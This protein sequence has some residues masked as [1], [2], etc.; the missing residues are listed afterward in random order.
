MARNLRFFRLLS[1]ES[2]GKFLR[3]QFKHRLLQNLLVGL[4]A[5]VGDKAALLCSE[6]VAGTTNV[7][8][9]HCNLNA[10]AQVAETLDGI[11]SAHCHRGERTLRRNGEVAERLAVAASHTP[12]ELVQI[13][14]TVVL[15]VVDNDGVH[16]RHVDATLDD[17][18][19]KQHVVV[20]VG[21][22][23]DAF[24]QFFGAHLTV[25]HHH[26]R[27]RHEAVNHIFEDGQLIDAVVHEKHLTVA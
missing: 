5:E 22:V 21:E 11:Q 10:G 19:G 9:L 15:G 20:V 17:G 7:K 3:F 27:V 1:L 12:T 26:T 24:F 13:A 6:Q 25:A 2:I 16:V 4:V 23:D 18:G 8:V 14:Q